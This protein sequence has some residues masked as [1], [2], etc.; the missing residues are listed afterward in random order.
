VIRQAHALCARLDGAGR[1]HDIR[2]VEGADDELR[3]YPKRRQLG[4]G[5]LHKDLLVLFADVHHLAHIGNAQELVSHAVGE[6][7]ELR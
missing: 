4:V 3:V 2:C 5:N 1:S 6:F 7:L